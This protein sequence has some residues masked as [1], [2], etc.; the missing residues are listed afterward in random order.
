MRLVALVLIL[1]CVG[2]DSSQWLELPANPPE[3]PVANI[4][5]SLRQ[6]NWADSRGSGSCVIASSCS[7]FQWINRPELV[8]LFRTQYAGGQTESSIKA[9]W[10][11]NRI[12]FVCTETD[13]EHG[14]PA[15][16]EW[17]TKTRRAA[18]IWYFPNHCVTFVGFGLWDGRE[19]AW[20]LDNNRVGQF[21]PID[22]QTFIRNWRSYGGFAAIP[23]EHPV[24]A[25]PW[26]GYKARS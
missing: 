17:A 7:A 24:P 21:I 16:L 1:F 6:T 14:D 8:K 19:V 13:A 3:M 22:K 9:K 12:P 25:R 10:R 11:A 18:I 4:P 26:Q 20:L 5:K 23:L 15:I 2:C